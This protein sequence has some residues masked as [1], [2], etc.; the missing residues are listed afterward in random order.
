MKTCTYAAMIFCLVAGTAVARTSAPPAQYRVELRS[1]DATRVVVHATLPSD[2]AVLSMAT[3]RPGDV[4]ELADAGWPALVRKLRVADESGNALVAMR[5]GA[6][7]WTLARPFTGT[8][9]LDYEIDYAPLAQRGWPAPREAAFRDEDHLTVV[10]RSLFITTPQQ[11]GSEVRFELPDAWHVVTPWPASDRDGAAAAGSIDDLVEN[12]IAFSRFAPAL[13]TSRDFKVNVVALGHW[14]PMLDDVQRTLG[15]L[16]GPLVSLIGDSTG[17]NY[18]VVL[19][20]PLERG[21]ESFRASFAMTLDEAPSRTNLAAWAGTIAHEIFHYWNGWRLRGA[22]YPSSQWFQEGFTEYAANLALVSSGLIGPDEFRATLARHIG[23]YDKLATPLDAPGSSKGPP[24]YSGGALVAFTWDTMIREASGDE[25]DL[26]DFLRAL[27][28]G[29]DGGARPYAW[30]DLQAALEAA[31]SADWAGFERRHIHGSEPLPLADALHRVG[32]RLATDSA[33]G[34]RVEI[35][36]EASAL[37]NA[38][39]RALAGKRES[40]SKVAPQ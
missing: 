18:L 31:A 36:G 39:G 1:A 30:S 14:R 32:L 16:L 23:N 12:L 3:S 40:P 9:S 7:G 38:R 35:D 6:S 17:G 5:N 33:D 21:G 27:W 34:P 26:G 29:T 20:P 10:G 2:G 13:V 25:R 11:T 37:A 24:L 8:L 15:A 19:L 22:D 4:P 28:R